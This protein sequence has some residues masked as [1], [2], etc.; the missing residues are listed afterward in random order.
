MQLQRLYRLGAMEWLKLSTRL[1]IV[2][3]LVVFVL[4]ALQLCFAVRVDLAAFATIE[5]P[6]AIY[7]AAFKYIDNIA[8]TFIPILF[9]VNVS[10]EFEYAVVQRS[11]VSG[12]TRN[13]YFF[14]KMMQLVFCSL[15][16]HISAIIFV[17]LTAVFYHLPMPTDYAR[18]VIYFPVSLC[19][20]SLSFLLVLLLNKS[21]W[22]LA[23]FIAYV[24]L[25]N[26][27]NLLLID[28]GLNLLL[29]FQT[30]VSMLRHNI[31]GNLEFLMMATYT[32]LFLMV[33][34]RQFM[35]MD[36]Q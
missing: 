24:F 1:N 9:L 29:P 6:Q 16:A 35:R 4:V 27:L 8:F 17:V 25:E 22:S 34:Y 31:H 3:S 2:F 26:F 10:K 23:A 20:N 13:D 21:I 7:R 14:S 30:C 33:S 36:L 11:L 32:A 18:M 15:I 28:K 12:L 5:T 19:L